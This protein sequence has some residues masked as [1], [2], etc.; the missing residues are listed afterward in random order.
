[1]QINLNGDQIEIKESSNL[2]DVLRSYLGLSEPRAVAVAINKEIIPKSEWGATTLRAND[3]IEVLTVS[4][5][6]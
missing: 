1:M 4:Q 6:G 2:D 5:G 3:K